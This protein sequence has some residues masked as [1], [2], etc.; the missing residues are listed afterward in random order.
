[1]FLAT[2]L[3]FSLL[4]PHVTRPAAPASANCSAIAAPSPCVPPVTTAI[5]P[6]ILFISVLPRACNKI[7]TH[8]DC[9][10]CIDKHAEMQHDLRKG[11]IK[12]CSFCAAQGGK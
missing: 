6:S 4:R 1:M 5:F 3:P 2:A 10:T 11:C 7:C 9:G 8:I 12:R